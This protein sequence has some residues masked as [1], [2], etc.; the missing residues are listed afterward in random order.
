MN[1]Q[2][3]SRL[4]HPLTRNS[5]R[6]RGPRPSKAAAWGALLAVAVLAAVAAGVIGGG[7]ALAH[8]GLGQSVQDT[9]SGPIVLEW[10]DPPAASG[11]VPQI[12]ADAEDAQPI[13][14]F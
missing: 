11:P 3:R 8:R 14:T 10:A 9:R 6:D 5:S 1:P 13:A 2:H 12:P 7:S 4:G